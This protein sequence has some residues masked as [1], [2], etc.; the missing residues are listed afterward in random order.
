MTKNDYINAVDK[1]EPSAEFY[2][3]AERRMREAQRAKTK[4]VNSSL[5]FKWATAAC[6]L[7]VAVT[8]ATL[9]LS[10]G[11]KFT[12]MND[13]AAEAE[14]SAYGGACALQAGEENSVAEDVKEETTV[15][16][17]AGETAFG[18]SNGSAKGGDGE[19]NAPATT[20]AVKEDK[21]VDDSLDEITPVESVPETTTV[22]VTAV[23]ETTTEA[24]A[25]PCS[26]DDDEITGGISTTS[27]YL[28]V[29]AEIIVKGGK[30]YILITNKSGELIITGLDYELYTFGDGNRER[31][32]VAVDDLAAEVPDG[33]TLEIPIDVKLGDGKYYVKK[34]FS[35]LDYTAECKFAVKDGKI[36]I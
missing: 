28:P 20:E 2:E 26:N 29:E 21:A 10:N 13:K 4:S 36:V 25:N 30:A 9:V 16:T 34:Y 8:G 3:K 31:I 19:K 11:Y 24:V 15:E 27:A 14:P 18:N 35:E 33:K 32:E 5:A 1:I 23:P 12:A 17:T 7:V 6:A 22:A